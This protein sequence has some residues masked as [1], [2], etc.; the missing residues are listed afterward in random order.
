MASG[1]QSPLILCPEC[2]QVF[3]SKKLLKTHTSSIHQHTTVEENQERTEKKKE[4][5][6]MKMRTISWPFL[7][8]HEEGD[9]LKLKAFKDDKI[10]N[11]RRRDVSPFN[12]E[13]MT[14]TRNLELRRAMAK[15]VHFN[16]TK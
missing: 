2:K 7:V 11:V 1:C 9:F 15:A 4:V 13:K 5:V 8:I 12:L 10:H 14:E 3:A 6:L 16:N